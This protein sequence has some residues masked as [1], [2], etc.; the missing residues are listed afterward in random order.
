MLLTLILVKGL[1]VTTTTII[2]S[3]LAVPGIVLGVLSQE[4]LPVPSPQVLRY[5][6][7]SRS[8]GR[9]GASVRRSQVS[10]PGGHCEFC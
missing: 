7:H 9:L 3:L 5:Y 4:N 1:I 6:L 8:R 2:D 10:R